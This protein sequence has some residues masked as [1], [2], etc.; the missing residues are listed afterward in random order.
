M[1]SISV[2]M[3]AVVMGKGQRMGE[4]RRMGKG[5][6]F[7][8]W[9]VI[10]ICAILGILLGALVYQRVETKRQSKSLFVALRA[11]W[12]AQAAIQ[13]ALLKFRILPTES[14]D[15]SALA[16]GVCPFFVADGPISTGTVNPA[17]LEAF[18]LDIDSELYPFSSEFSSLDGFSYSVVELRA[19]NS[20]NRDT[21]RVHVV[22]IKAMG[23]WD[24]VSG[25]KAMTYSDE[26]V[27]TVDVERSLAL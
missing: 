17:P 2:W 1:V 25:G 15:A 13:H 26:L 8:I 23:I 6:G 7:A 27:K 12:A 10:F 21:K 14:Y 18:R 19:L 16:R 4:R 24:G 3:N 5:R 22:Q 9:I 20:F 11:Q